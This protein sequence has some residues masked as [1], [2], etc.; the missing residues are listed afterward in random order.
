MFTNT[1]A[2]VVV[3]LLIRLIVHGISVNI[4][5]AKG[6]THIRFHF[7]IIVHWSSYLPPSFGPLCARVD[8]LGIV[9]MNIYLK[10]YIIMFHFN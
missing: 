1:I 3:V 2:S 5:Y 4:L 6:S 8:L 10:K 9:N 7:A